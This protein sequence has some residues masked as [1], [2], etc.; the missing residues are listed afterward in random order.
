MVESPVAKNHISSAKGLFRFEGYVVCGS[1]ANA[2][3]AGPS[4][5]GWGSPTISQPNGA[6]T[7]PL[8]ITR[9]TT[10]GKLRLT[11]RFTRDATEQ[12]LL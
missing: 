3:D 11:Q 12:E 8:T 9:D 6:N 2:W 7:V 4:E 1:G 10:N 5:S